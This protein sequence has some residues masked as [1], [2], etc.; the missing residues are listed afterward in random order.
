MTEVVR[1]G[2][3]SCLRSGA[4]EGRRTGGQPPACARSSAGPISSGR[5]SGENSEAVGEGQLGGDVGRIVGDT[6][7]DPDIEQGVRAEAYRR[8]QRKH[9]FGLVR[10]RHLAAVHFR[11]VSELHREPGA[12]GYPRT[13]GENGSEI[14]RPAVT[15][16]DVEALLL[17]LEA[18]GIAEA[19]EEHDWIIGLE[20]GHPPAKTVEA[21]AECWTVAVERI[22]ARGQA[23]A[24]LAEQ[25]R[26]PA[27]L[28]QELVR[29]GKLDIAEAELAAAGAAYAVGCILA[30]P[31]I[32]H[33]QL[34]LRAPGKAEPGRDGGLELV[35]IGLVRPHAAH[36]VLLD[37]HEAVGTL[38]GVDQL[39]LQLQ[40]P[41]GQEDATLLDQHPVER[42]QLRIALPLV[43]GTGRG[44]SGRLLTC[45]YLRKCRV[46][47]STWCSIT[48]QTKLM[49]L[50]Q[51]LLAYLA[52]KPARRLGLVLR[53]R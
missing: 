34:G 48:Y 38:V 32:G 41:R 2:A 16:V 36:A 5:L 31:Q 3:A 49:Q 30:Y 4:A 15:R 25:I 33:P 13:S 20:Q 1:S 24:Q 10:A 44:R 39:R 14:D 46:R 43:L 29:E 35:T 28:A 40:G 42:V 47:H 9:T 17:V 37:D 52:L 45:D 18:R 50:R 21:A 22:F 19:A 53:Y 27:I 6:D 23:P 12:Q 7:P 51:D 8:A 26:H 11:L